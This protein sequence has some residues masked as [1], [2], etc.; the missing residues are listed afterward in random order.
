LPAMSVAS[1]ITAGTDIEV[2]PFQKAGIA[3]EIGL[4]WRRKTPRAAEFRMLGDRVRACTRQ[5][6]GA[7]D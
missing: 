6:V 4:M 2:T 5:A 7:T 3:R 1:G